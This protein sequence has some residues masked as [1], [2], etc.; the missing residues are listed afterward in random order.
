MSSLQRARQLSMRCVTSWILLAVV[1][2]LTTH[3]SHGAARLPSPAKGATPLPGPVVPSTIP[4]LQIAHFP[5]AYPN[6]TH[7]CTAGSR[8]RSQSC[9]TG[10]PVNA[11]V[12]QAVAPSQAISRVLFGSCIKQDKPIPI[13]SAILAQRPELMVFLGDN[14]YADTTDMAVMRAKYARLKSDP[15]FSRLLTTCPVLATWDDH[16]YGAND[17]GADYAKRRES[18]RIF[19]DFWSDAPDSP[20]RQRPGVYS[21]QLFGPAEKRLQVI[22]LDTRYFRGP[23]TRGK[24]RVGGPYY[25]NLDSQ[26]TMLGETQWNWLQQQLRQPAQVRIIVSSIQCVSAAAGQETWSNLPHERQRLFQLIRTT[27]AEGVLLISGDRHWAELSVTAD[28]TPYP[29][30]DL[31]SSSFNQPHRRGTPTVNRYRADPM[32]YHRENFGAI[33]I[34]WNRADPLITLRIQDLQGHVQIERGLPLSTLKF[35]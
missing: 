32:T 34:D 33:H 4:P 7:A 16:D 22:L 3:L 2:H 27:R 8:T 24:K 14:I 20:R 21:A 35:P 26:V 9:L 30:Y 12:A 23:L 5:A 6:S 11:E 19:L 1:S 17:A 15:G 31:T 13:F 25:P 10:G 29:I 28:A 18:Q